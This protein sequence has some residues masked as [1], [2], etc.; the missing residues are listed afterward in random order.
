MAL[1]N[2]QIEGEDYVKTFAL[3]VKMV[4]VRLYLDLAAKRGWEIHQM[5]VH[6]TFLHGDL[7]EKVYSCH[8]DFKQLI[9][10]RYVVC[11][12]PCMV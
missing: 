12:N 5:D 6:N 1:G 7:A 9:K 4:T 8:L 2:K 11:A 10:I 3:V